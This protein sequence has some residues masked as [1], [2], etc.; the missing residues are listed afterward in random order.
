MKILIFSLFCAFFAITDS[1]KILA[2]FP[3]GSF[4]HYAIGESTLKAL[5]EAGHEVT[6]ISSMK[7]KKPME[8]FKEIIIDDPM[9]AMMKGSIESIFGFLKRI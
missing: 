4:S 3:F 6:M 7:T 9:K 1:Y 2:V 5:T 8:H